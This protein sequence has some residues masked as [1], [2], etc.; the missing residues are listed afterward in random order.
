MKFLQDCVIELVIEFF[1]QSLNE[2]GKGFVGKF[3]R[4]FEIGSDD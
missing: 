2:F 4:E 3:L 1:E